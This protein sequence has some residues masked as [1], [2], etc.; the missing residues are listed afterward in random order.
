MPESSRLYEVAI[1]GGGP[2]GL[3]LGLCLE[4]A[5]ISCII[6]EKRQQP[7]S[8]SR[9]LGIHPVCLELF[10]SLE[11]AGNLVRE[12]LHI[13]EGHA[14][15][16]NRRLG[17]L[18]FEHCPEPYNFILA[19]PQ[20]RT[21]ALLETELNKRNSDILL[22]DAV[23]NQ[24]Q[25]KEDEVIVGFHHAGGT[26]SVSANYLIGCD[27]KNSF[28]RQKCGIPF[29]G[30]HYPDTYIM[31][32]FKDNTSFGN[33]AA[34][35]LCREG[36]IESFPLPNNFRRWV[37]KT[38]RY[39]NTTTREDIESKVWHRIRH[40]L[41]HTENIML[42]SFGVQ[43]LIAQPMV[44]GRII[45]L[46]DA[47]HVISPIG[48]QGM[49]LGWLDAWDLSKTL[50]TLVNQRSHNPQLLKQYEQRRRKAFRNAARRAELNMRLGRQSPFPLLRDTLVSAMLRYPVSKLM[51][52]LFTMRGIEKGLI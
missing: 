51:A 24:I 4:Q 20:Q 18:S 9:S 10:D 17:S 27:G 38:N 13:Q 15:N 33:D 22:R 5:G 21:E 26:E 45:L 19:L 43:K 35:Y 2:I 31:G 46:G 32:D 50:S 8:G 49:N 52:N 14:F 7:R 6:L 36:L 44:R 29:E 30:K 34:I 11:M 39:K 42:S 47:A 16:N 12:G 23:V 3:F 37:V 25:E 41:T 48:G 40:S 1:V 28:V